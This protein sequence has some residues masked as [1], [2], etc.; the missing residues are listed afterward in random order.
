MMQSWQPEQ[1]WAFMVTMPS[2]CWSAPVGQMRAQGAFS[3]W[4]QEMGDF[5]E[6]L[7][8]TW[9]RATSSSR[10][11]RA[12]LKVRPW[13]AAIQAISQRRHALHFSGTDSIM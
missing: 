3:H 1:I 2:S 6:P 8:T 12:S 7:L 13:W 11:F 4:R 5:T 9:T 10:F